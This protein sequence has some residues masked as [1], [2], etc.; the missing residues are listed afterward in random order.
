MTVGGAENGDPRQPNSV[1]L[2]N[3]PDYRAFLTDFNLG[4]GCGMPPHRQLDSRASEEVETQRKLD[5]YLEGHWWYGLQG[6]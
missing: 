1:A 4:R 2:T 5:R 3:T 6:R